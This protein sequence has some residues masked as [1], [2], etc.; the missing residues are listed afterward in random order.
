MIKFFVFMQSYL[1]TREPHD[2][3]GAT[4]IEYALIVSFIALIALVGVTDFGVRLDGLFD[5]MSP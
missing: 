3:R 1:A 5:K 4:M 2:D